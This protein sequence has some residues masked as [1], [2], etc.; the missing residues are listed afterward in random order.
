M[1]NINTKMIAQKIKNKEARALRN[2]YSKGELAKRNFKGL[3]SRGNFGRKFGFAESPASF[4]VF[5][6]WRGQKTDTE[7]KELYTILK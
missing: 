3:G 2:N 5:W 7:L 4:K 1:K 6:E